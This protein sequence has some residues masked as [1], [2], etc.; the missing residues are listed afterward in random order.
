MYSP[1]H[2]RK[3]SDISPNVHSFF[4]ALIINGIK[5]VSLSVAVFNSSRLLVAEALSL[6]FLIFFNFLFDHL[7]IVHL[8][9]EDQFQHL[10]LRDNLNQLL[11]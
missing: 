10:L 9:V 5:F 8:F 3:I 7:L 6:F 2:P 11:M 4:A 1:K